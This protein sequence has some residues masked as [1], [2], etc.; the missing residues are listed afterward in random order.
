MRLHFTTPEKS[1]EEKE[2]VDELEAV[3][4]PVTI[5]IIGFGLLMI[6]LAL[7]NVPSP[8]F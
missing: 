5:F 7:G 2:E 8:T 3:K 1:E 6:A 4:Y